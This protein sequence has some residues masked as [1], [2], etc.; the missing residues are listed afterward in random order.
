MMQLMLKDNSSTKMQIMDRRTMSLFDDSKRLI[1]VFIAITLI[2]SFSNSYAMTIKIAT[3]APDGTTWMK[4]MRAAAKVIT[5][6]TEGR[7]SRWRHG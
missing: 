1:K 7:V 3:V 5:E 4:K 2:A 6:K